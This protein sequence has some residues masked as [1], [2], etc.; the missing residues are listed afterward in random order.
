MESQLNEELLLLAA[1]LYI[2]ASF[3]IIAGVIKSGRENGVESLPAPLAGPLS[4][5]SVPACVATWFVGAQAHS[6]MWAL[7]TAVI[8]VVASGVLAYY[9]SNKMWVKT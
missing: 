9:L 1:F 4:F 2:V 3:A 5:L 6:M 8:G 7:I